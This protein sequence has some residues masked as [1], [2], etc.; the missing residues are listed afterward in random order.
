MLHLRT[1]FFF[2]C[3]V[4]IAIAAPALAQDAATEGGGGGALGWILSNPLTL[5]TGIVT[6]AS[7][8]SAFV[9]SVGKFMR[10]V[11]F[12]ALNWLKA[13]NDPGAQ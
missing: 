9:P 13:R 12:F 1:S 6:A 11:D 10:F 7:A 3:L 8:I 5:I 4:L 2:V